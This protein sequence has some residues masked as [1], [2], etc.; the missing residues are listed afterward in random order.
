VNVLW[1]GG[2][3]IHEFR[4][5]VPVR[6][7]NCKTSAAG[8]AI[9][10]DQGV[11]TVTWSNS[12]DD[13]VPRTKYSLGSARGIPFRVVGNRINSAPLGVGKID[14]FDHSW[15]RLARP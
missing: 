8:E 2:C 15:P 5:L 11:R 12:P 10:P 4:V 9:G 3:Q 13:C 6:S 14:V 7:K 1:G